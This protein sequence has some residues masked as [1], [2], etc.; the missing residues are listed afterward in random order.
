M[1]LPGAGGSPAEPDDPGTVASYRAAAA[2]LRDLAMAAAHAYEAERAAQLLRS[3]AA[4][5]TRADEL[6]REARRA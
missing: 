6:E 3:A 5:D 1:G 4:L 2:R